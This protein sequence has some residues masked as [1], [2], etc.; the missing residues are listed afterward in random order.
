MVIKF[1]NTHLE[2]LTKGEPVQGEGQLDKQA[3]FM[4][5]KTLRILQR[6]PDADS[7]KVLDSLQ[8]EDLNG[9]MKDLYAV[10]VDSNSKLVFAIERDRMIVNDVIIVKELIQQ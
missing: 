6:M 10:R 3:I 4:L 5:K 8:F 9:D 7:L 1:G 2:A